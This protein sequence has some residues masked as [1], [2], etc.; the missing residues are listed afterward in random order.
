MKEHPSKK[1]VHHG[2]IAAVGITLLTVDSLA[3]FGPKA[4]ARNT[5]VDI[6]GYWAQ[7]CIEQLA[8]RD[9]LTGYP[10]GTF[11][12]NAPL[13]K[14]E[15]AAIL[16]K[17][18]PGANQVR[19]TISFKDVPPES[20][21]ANAI[22]TAQ[23]RGFISGSSY[24]V[25]NPNQQVSRVEALVSLTNGLKYKPTTLTVDDLN[26]VFDDAKDIPE[27]ARIGILAAIEKRL[28]V[29]YPQIR[30]LNPNQNVT[31]SEVATFLCQATATSTQP[32]GVPLEYIVDIPTTT[33]DAQTDVQT[34]G[35]VRAE[36]S[37]QKQNYALSNLRLKI[38]RQG[39]TLLDQ[40]IPV[41]GSINRSVGVTV[42]DLDGDGEPEVL[43][44]I[45]TR[46]EGCCSYSLIYRYLRH[47]NSYISIQQN[48]GNVKYKLKENNQDNLPEFDSFNY[49]FALPS[50]ENQTDLVFPRQI[51]QYRQGQMFDVTRQRPD[52]VRSHA[53]MLWQNYQQRLQAKQDVKGVLAAYLADKCL[54]GQS[55]EGWSDVQRVYDGADRSEY[56]INLQTSLRNAGYLR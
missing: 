25:F 19:P 3:F 20:W 37:Y 18:F 27:Y 23:E 55:Q 15:F 38:I 44:D 32:S 2:A 21:S 16:L 53:T 48:W 5:F 39:Q 11:K 7:N 4:L 28:I 47:P 14:A 54:L 51:W 6:Q 22:Q 33:Q 36:V 13:T 45:F 24:Q 12:P 52:L 46:G 8:Q 1:F 42:R 26:K 41:Q 49:K 30:L 29:N 31:R 10:D 43:V 35:N 17:A 9:I 40:I 56:L 50:E 34:F